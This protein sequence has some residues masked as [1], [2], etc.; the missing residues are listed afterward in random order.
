MTPAKPFACIISFLMTGHRS[1]YPSQI[2]SM[3]K[4][5]SVDVE[6]GHEISSSVVYPHPRKRSF[7]GLLIRAWNA[8]KEAMNRNNH[9]E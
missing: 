4:S 1:V 6:L 9:S 2:L 8:I 5:T 7:T 3:R